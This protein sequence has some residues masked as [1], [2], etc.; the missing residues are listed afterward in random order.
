MQ[1]YFWAGSDYFES[2]T[3]IHT[4]HGVMTQLSH[5]RMCEDSHNCHI[6]IPI[7]TPQSVS[8]TTVILYPHLGN[9]I[10]G[11]HKHTENNKVKQSSLFLTI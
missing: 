1:G 9:D 11:P 7:V 4:Y 3:K 2:W 6:S 5:F 10:T 8:N